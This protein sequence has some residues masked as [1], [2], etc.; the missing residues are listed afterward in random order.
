MTKRCDHTSA[1]MIVRQGDKV[2]LIERM[3]YPFGFA[4]PAGHVDGDENFEISARRELNEE[5]GLEATDL[6]LIF[7]GRKENRC[8]REDGT[9]HY[10]KIYEIKVTG[11]I[12]RS[13]DETKQVGWY[14]S[15]EIEKLMGRTKQYLLS[16]VSE[17][18]WEKNPGLEVFWFNLQ[19]ET[20]KVF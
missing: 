16:E 4:P 20:Q 9:W 18:E 19:S 2:L 14:S 12:K 5:V 15:Q 6:K 10:W 13:K 3:K 8:R 1:G 7:E 17:E 11:E